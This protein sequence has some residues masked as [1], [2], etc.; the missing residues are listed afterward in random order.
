MMK[1]FLLVFIGLSLEYRCT[2][3]RNNTCSWHILS[4]LDCVL[5]FRS[6]C[7]DDNLKIFSFLLSNISSLKSTLTTCHEVHVVVLV[8]ILTREDKCSWS[9]LTCNGVNHSS[10][11]LFSITWTVGIKVREYTKSR[12]SLN[13]L[14]G[15][16]IF[17]NSDGVMG[18]DVRNASKL[19]KGCNT[20]GWAKVINE[21]S[22]SRSGCL[23]DSVVSNTVKDGSHSVF[24]DSEVQVLSRVSL[25][26]SSSEVS[27]V[28]D[29]VTA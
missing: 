10:N 11:S 27:S 22:E 12:N 17:S 16:S 1:N 7:K 20:D 2:W 3:H 9:F 24:T 19:S 13:R 28:F 15:W 26:E 25:V 23:E 21:N 29:V 6:S 8:H 18:K 4:Y 5:K 14:V